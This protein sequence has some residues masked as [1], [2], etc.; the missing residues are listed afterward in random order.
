[1]LGCCSI[2]FGFCHFARVDHAAPDKLRCVGSRGSNLSSS[3]VGKHGVK[4]SRRGLFPEKGQIDK[5]VGTGA[6]S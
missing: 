6:D 2:G 3:P 1:M 5:T 4:S